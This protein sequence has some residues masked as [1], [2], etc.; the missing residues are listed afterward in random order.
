MSTYGKTVLPK[1]QA[2][3]LGDWP[4]FLFP[5]MPPIPYLSGSPLTYIQNYRPSPISTSTCEQRYYFWVR[6]RGTWI[7]SFNSRDKVL[8]L[9]RG[10]VVESTSYLGN[11]VWS[12]V[13]TSTVK[14]VALTDTGVR[15]KHLAP[16][17]SRQ[18]IPVDRAWRRMSQTPW[19]GEEWALREGCPV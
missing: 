1:A 14:V 11:T 13:G 19:R 4:W 8:A 3:Y 10:T 15:C 7:S 5:V 17:W 18:G 12:G 6:E 2:M 9:E 16:D